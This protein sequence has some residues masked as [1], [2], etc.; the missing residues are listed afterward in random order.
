MLT[1][2]KPF[3]GDTPEEILRSQLNREDSFRAPRDLNG[4]IPPAVEKTILKCLER[5][6][7]KRHPIISVLVVELKAALYV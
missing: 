1:G 5:D 3:A 2:Q 6:P 4:E 7:D